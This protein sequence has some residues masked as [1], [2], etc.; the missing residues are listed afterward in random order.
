MVASAKNE[1]QDE[2]EEER[3]DLRTIY[4]ETRQDLFSGLPPPANIWPPGQGASSSAACAAAIPTPVSLS[5]SEPEEDALAVIADSF[6]V[7]Q[8]ADN[9]SPAALTSTMTAL[10]LAGVPSTNTT[11]D[12]V[13]VSLRNNLWLFPMLLPRPKLSLH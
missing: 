7:T 13:L 6:P 11:I 1:L 12:E 3:A 2:E 10:T 8:W 4:V 5:D 9:S